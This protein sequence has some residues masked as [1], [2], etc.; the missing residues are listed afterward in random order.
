M[1]GSAQMHVRRRRRG[2]LASLAILPTLLAVAVA[3][4]GCGGAHRDAGPSGAY[5]A[6]LHNAL[7]ADVRTRGVLRIATD[8]SYA[9]ASSFGPDGRTIV[10]FEPDLG[11]ALGR[12]L[13]VKVRFVNRDFSGIL[14]DVAAR[15]VDL[16]MS[17]VTDTPERERVVDFVNYFSAGTAI[18]VQ[19]GNPG[20]VTDLAGLCGRTAAVEKGTVQVDLLARSQRQCHGARI[21]VREYDTNADALVQL[22]TGRATAVL[23]DYPPAVLLATDAR[24]RANYQLASTAQYEPGLYGIAVARSEPRLRD[25]VR[26][27]LNRVIRAGEYRR[28]LQRWG[29]GAGGV[30][31]AAVNGKDS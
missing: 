19:R 25:A 23:N 14:R 10:G 26:V 21:H 7:P 3:V 22:R 17:A 31:Q 16:A 27:A 4:A 29:V 6:A 20:G 18:V 5:D 28:V 2:L 15:R 8:A 24:T 12:V 30:P 11:A 9:P 1:K 13:G